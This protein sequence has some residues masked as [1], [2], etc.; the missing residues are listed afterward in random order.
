[1]CV[2]VCVCVCVRACVRVCVRVSLSPFA[3]HVHTVVCEDGGSKKNKIKEKNIKKHL[4]A[5]YGVERLVC[6]DGKGIQ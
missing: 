4:F 1:M 6:E 2:C 3:W 5:V